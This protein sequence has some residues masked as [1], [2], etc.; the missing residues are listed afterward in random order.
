MFI[1]FI[2]N[3]ILPLGVK[4]SDSILLHLNKNNIRL[5]SSENTANVATILQSVVTELK[6]ISERKRLINMKLNSSTVPSS[7]ETSSFVT[8]CEV[9]KQVPTI[10]TVSVTSRE[11]ASDRSKFIVGLGTITSTG[12]STALTQKSPTYSSLG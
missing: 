3:K 4:V 1:D 2:L 8:F 11:I 7:S 5:E 9:A 10:S 6:N 12:L